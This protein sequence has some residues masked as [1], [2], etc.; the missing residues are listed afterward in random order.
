MSAGLVV[1]RRGYQLTVAG[2]GDATCLALV[3]PGVVLAAHLADVGWHRLAARLVAT[4]G[5]A[6][7]VDLVSVPS[8][9]R[10]A[11]LGRA[12]LA[13]AAREAAEQGVDA[14]WL[15]GVQVDDVTRGELAAFYRACGF[16]AAG[17]ED[18]GAP[19]FVRALTSAATSVV[20]AVATP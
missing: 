1:E 18:D 16:A 13:L 6:A 12:M 9:A 19:L 7:Y 14:V 4:R 17:H 2:P 11:G 15:H 8:G 3:A 10:R 5:L 20:S